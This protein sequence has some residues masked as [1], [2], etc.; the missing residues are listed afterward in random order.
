MEQNRYSQFK[1]RAK[2]LKDIILSRMGKSHKIILEPKDRNCQN[3]LNNSQTFD[4][5]LYKEQEYIEI[6]SKSK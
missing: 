4:G 3:L 6:I 5:N 2:V 1:S